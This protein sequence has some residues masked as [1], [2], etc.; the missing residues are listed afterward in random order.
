MDIRDVNS[1]G[2]NPADEARSTRGVGAS[3]S[4]RNAEPQSNDRVTLSNRAQAFQEARRA[5]LD[6]PDV[7]TDRVEA[8]RRQ[9]Q[10]GSLVPDPDRIAKA[11][12]AQGVVGS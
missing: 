7:R 6:V 10:S 12:L 3:S 5:A 8:L 9:V 4:A 2:T 1:R 11:L